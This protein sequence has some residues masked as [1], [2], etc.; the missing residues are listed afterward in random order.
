M[1][2]FFRGDFIKPDHAGQA[3]R[4]SAQLHKKAGVLCAGEAGESSRAEGVRRVYLLIPFFASVRL[5]FG[6][7][8]LWSGEGVEKKSPCQRGAEGIV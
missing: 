4:W 5:C 3:F 7:V 6:A 8:A 1:H 2:K